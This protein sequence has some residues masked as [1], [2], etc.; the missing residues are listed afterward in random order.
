MRNLI[1]GIEYASRAKAVR[2]AVSVMVDS[3]LI[4]T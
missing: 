2:T 1:S 4:K 3:P